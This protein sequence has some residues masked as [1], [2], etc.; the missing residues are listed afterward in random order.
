MQPVSKKKMEKS[1]KSI[2]EDFFQ[3]PEDL[4]DETDDEFQDELNEDSFI[5]PQT[6]LQV[7]IIQKIYYSK[8][9]INFIEFH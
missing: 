9:L 1:T 3:N 4:E 5:D 7:I 2:V 8:F 6:Q